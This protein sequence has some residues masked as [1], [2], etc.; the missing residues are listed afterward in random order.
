MPCTKRLHKP[1]LVACPFAVAEQPPERNLGT[2]QARI[3]ITTNY[4]SSHAERRKPKGLIQKNPIPA[5]ETP[6]SHAE[7]TLYTLNGE[8]D[9]VVLCSVPLTRCFQPVHAL[10]S[11]CRA[12]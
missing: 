6:K 11:R 8:P 1:P 5:E 3:A 10:L 7:N 9:L 4:H 2:W 12:A